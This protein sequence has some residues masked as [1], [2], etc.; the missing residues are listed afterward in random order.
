MPKYSPKLPLT[1]DKTQPGYEHITEMLDLVRQNMKMIVLTNPGERVMM[2]EFGVG[3]T[4]LLFENIEDTE[5]ISEF[6]GRIEDQVATYLPYVD[7]VNIQFFEN[8]KDANKL[9]TLIEYEIPA[10]GESDEVLV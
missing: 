2:P 10:L 1:I 3:I 6:E 4:G 7:I 9:S 8:E 5:T